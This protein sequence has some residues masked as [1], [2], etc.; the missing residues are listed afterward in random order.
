MATT[1]S[2]NTRSSSVKRLLQESKELVNLKE[3]G[4]YA[5]PLEDNLHEFHFT[6][7]GPADSEFQGGIYHG[8]ILVSGARG[9]M[10]F[11]TCN[12]AVSGDDETDG[13]TCR[14]PGSSRAVAVL[15][16]ATSIP[17]LW[18]LPG[19]RLAACGHDVP[20][21]H[22]TMML[23]SSTDQLPVV[24]ISL[25][26]LDAILLSICISSQP[27]TLSKRQVGVTPPPRLA[28]RPR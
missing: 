15:C 10:H 23:A 19:P 18:R 1:S 27:P 20:D 3:D 26:S 21:N 5:A 24:S 8:R 2:Y 9:C 6:I 11:C 25:L 4:I 17:S 7:R 16:C 28:P 12:A 13:R 22:T 14:A